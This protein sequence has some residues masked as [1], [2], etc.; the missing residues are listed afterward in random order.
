[1]AIA[2]LLALAVPAFL[3]RTAAA[4]APDDALARA[5]QEGDEAAVRAALA[6][7]AKPNRPLADGSTPLAWAVESQ[8]RQIVR[9]LLDRGAKPNGMP[10]PLTLACQYGD[11]AILEMLLTARA[12]VKAARAD[13]ITPLAVCAGNAPTSI[14]KRLIAAGA[15]VDAADNNGQTPLMWAAAKGRVENIPLLVEHGAAINRRTHKGF[16]PLFF[17][18]KSGEPRAPVAVLEAGGDA[19]YVAPDGTSVV[20]LAM[21]QKDYAFAARM[22]ERGA[23]LTAFDRNGYQLLHAAVLANEPSLVKLLLA[24]GTDPNALTGTSKVRWRYEVNFTSAPYEAVPKSPL[25]L[26]AERGAPDLMRMLVDAGADTKFRAADGTNIVLASTSSGKLA[27]LELALQLEPDPNTTTADGQ[28]PLHLLLGGEAR[29][30]TEATLEIAAM[31]KLLAEKG[32]RTDI[33]NRAGQTPAD[34]AK[35]AEASARA[36]FETAFGKRLARNP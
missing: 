23:N 8:S 24:K 18:L 20:Q 4:G 33:R 11:A 31:M 10:S 15:E 34:V 17:A 25:L 35:D 9:L 27:A 29:T 36:A 16:T 7:H 22:I 5:V 6:H 14:L 3:P 2:G 21:Y 30:D 26:A 19:D 13:G 32:A 28:T 1:M 12:D